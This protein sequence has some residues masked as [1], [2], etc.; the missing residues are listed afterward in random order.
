MGL[1]R[2]KL[3]VLLCL[4]LS[5]ESELYPPTDPPVLSNLVL[6]SSSYKEPTTAAIQGDT[7]FLTVAVEDPEGDPETL[8]LSITSN[9][10]EVDRV[11]YGESRIHD[12]AHWEGWFETAGLGVGSYTLNFTASDK[13]GNIGSTLS[14]SF[15]IETNLKATVTIADI[16]VGLAGDA[17]DWL[18]DGE[19]SDIG[20]GIDESG[21]PFRA[22]FDITNNSS[23]LIDLVNIKL[24]VLDGA[25]AVIE[26][27]VITITA[28]AA[29]ETR[30][31]QKLK[32][33]I[34]D[35]VAAGVSQVIYVP[36]ES[37]IVIY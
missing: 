31:D 22:V 37:S 25:S 17:T 35:A 7:V 4:L 8:T 1:R 20:D 14:Q 28:L 9:G 32:L 15:N 26:G 3:P 29:G 5:C 2:L 10:T 13:E 11:E 21:E 6:T 18:E 36:A 16:T 24:N 34:L 27:D 23:L 19:D 30:T 12:G 33:N